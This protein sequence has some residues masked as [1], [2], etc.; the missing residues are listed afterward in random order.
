MVGIDVGYMNAGGWCSFIFFCYFLFPHVSS[1]GILV[2]FFLPL[3]V[4]R[5]FY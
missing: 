4:S 2:H 5:L 3:V 1:L